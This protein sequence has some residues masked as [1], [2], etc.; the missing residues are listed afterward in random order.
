MS[1]RAAHA[2][3]PAARA[4]VLAGAALLP[5]LLVL[6]ALAVDGRQRS[7]GGVVEHGGIVAAAAHRPVGA[8]SPAPVP[9]PR[10][11]PLAVGA[12]P[13]LSCAFSTP[14]RW[15]VVWG[16]LDRGP[17]WYSEARA[18]KE[19][20]ARVACEVDK[21]P[22]SA[23][24]AAVAARRQ[25][26]AQPGYRERAFT[27]VRVAGS[28][29]WRLAFERTDGGRRV[30]EVQLFLPDGVRLQVQAPRSRFARLAPTFARVLSLGAERAR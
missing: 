19:P 16:D 23:S 9:A 21:A 5:P 29:G 17:S 26:E 2:T 15:A 7:A 18:P 28:D 14:R 30:R 24:A 4:A 20:L 22:T 25:A 8:A 1:I 3:S 10:V 11:H 12:F 13:S 27:R 6:G